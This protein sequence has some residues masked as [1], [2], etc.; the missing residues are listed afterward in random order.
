MKKMSIEREE[1]TEKMKE[2]RIS[3]LPQNN[4]HHIK[5][6]KK[7]YSGLNQTHCQA[8]SGPQA[9]CLTAQS[10]GQCCL[11]KHALA[12]WLL[13]PWEQLQYEETE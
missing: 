8:C 11:W 7:T 12:L 9:T 4:R 6:K 5:R 2:E 3:V 1:A 13:S 10:R